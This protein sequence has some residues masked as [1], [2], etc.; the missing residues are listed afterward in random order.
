MKD[1]QAVYSYLMSLVAIYCIVIYIVTKELLDYG[2]LLSSIREFICRTGISK[3][4]LNLII[5]NKCI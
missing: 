1:K 4:I 3:Y 5:D 2:K